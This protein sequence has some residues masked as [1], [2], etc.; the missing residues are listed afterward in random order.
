MQRGRQRR[1]ITAE[2]KAPSGSKGRAEAKG[3]LNANFETLAGLKVC[4]APC[5]GPKQEQEKTNIQPLHFRL[6]ENK[7]FETMAIYHLSA[8]IISR[9]TGRSAT[10]AA[11]YRAAERIDD[12]LTG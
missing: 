6:R 11:A 7:E 12:R 8:K 10:A 9:K 3:A 1:R 2:P 4:R 5:R